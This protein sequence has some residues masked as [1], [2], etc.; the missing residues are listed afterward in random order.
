MENN[1]PLIASERIG[2]AIRLVRG[3][4]VGS[5]KGIKF[6]DY[7]DPPH[8]TQ[9]KSLLEGGSA[10][11]QATKRPVL[12]VSYCVGAGRTPHKRRFAKRIL[13][14]FGAPVLWHASSCL[15]DLY[16]FCPTDCALAKDLVQRWSP[17][18]RSPGTG[19]P[20]LLVCMR[21]AHFDLLRPFL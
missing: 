20:S 5:G 8:E 4:K 9:M 13:C 12:W 19:T 6:S 17:E 1:L 15:A 7:Y 16:S 14:L 3:Q 10:R 11:P 18:S 2:S 21:A